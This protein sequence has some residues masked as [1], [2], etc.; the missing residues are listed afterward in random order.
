MGNHQKIVPLL[1]SRLSSEELRREF[2]LAAKYRL[3]I[4]LG[5]ILAAVS[6]IDLMDKEKYINAKGEDRNT[7]LHYAAKN[8]HVRA[9]QLLLMRRANLK[10]VNK[11]VITPLALA[12][13]TPSLDS[14][15]LLLDAGAS[16]ETPTRWKRSIL[17][18]AI[19]NENKAAV[20]LLLDY[21]AATLSY[22][23]SNVLKVL[24][25][26]YNKRRALASG[27]PLQK[28]IPTPTAALGLIIS[29]GEPASFDALIKVWNKFKHP[30][31]DGDRGR[32]KDDIDI[33]KVGGYYGTALQAAAGAR[34]VLKNKTAR[35]D[36]RNKPLD[37][38]QTSEI[39]DADAL[40]GYWGTVLHAAT[41]SKDTDTVAVILNLRSEL[42][43]Q[44]DM[45]GRLPLHIAIKGSW[46][47]AI[48]VSS[49]RST[50][51]TPDRQGRTSLHVACGYGNTLLVEEILKD[52]RLKD[53]LIH[54]TDMD[55]WTPLHW[56]CRSGS[57]TLIKMLIE[58]KARIEDETTTPAG[59]LPFHVAVY[60]GQTSKLLTELQ[61]G[62][63]VL[64][65]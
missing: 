40:I 23:S 28:E 51:S 19:A 49:I 16:T 14:M 61:L 36:S 37:Q 48:Q 45:M 55:G 15:K 46:E 24:L 63:T 53:K 3:E 1:I 10:A 6:D 65:I 42:K 64:I 43:D 22:S 57:L 54:K 34:V 58:K 31:R 59:W 5:L 20:Q 9:V 52:N 32:S 25:K 29:R 44:A 50:I 21:R 38:S 47:L 60:H 26:H 12:S 13:Q 35:E 33:N 8:N 41:F 39:S 7:P 62:D 2:I 27:G 17:T 11:L 30:I 56:A 18:E 4:T